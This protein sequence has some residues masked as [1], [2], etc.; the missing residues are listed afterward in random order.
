[1]CHL[2]APRSSARQLPFG[3]RDW[4]RGRLG[5]PQ[6]ARDWHDEGLWHG[7]L[8]INTKQAGALS[9]SLRHFYWPG[10]SGW[11]ARLSAGESPI[12]GEEVAEAVIDMPVASCT[13]AAPCSLVLVVSPLDPIPL[14]L[15]ASSLCQANE[16]E[17]FYDANTRAANRM[18]KI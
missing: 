16:I 9:G 4:V 13:C 17:N 14:L 10:P 6:E 5:D 7:W 15:M 1:M 18:L 3:G 8:I 11:T 12:S 2:P